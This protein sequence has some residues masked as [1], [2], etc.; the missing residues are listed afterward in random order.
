MELANITLTTDL[1]VIVDEIKEAAY[2]ASIKNGVYQNIVPEIGK[3]KKGNEVVIPVWEADSLESRTATEG[4]LIGEPIK[5]GNDTVR[6]TAKESYANTF[7]TYNDVEDATDDVKRRHANALGIA[8]ARD[9]EI[10]GQEAVKG[11]TKSLVTPDELTIADIMKMRAMLEMQEKYADGNYQCVSNS[12]LY[13]SLE[14]SL[15]DNPAFGTRGEVGDEFMKRYAI[16]TVLGNIDLLRSDT[17]VDPEA[18]TQD[19]AFFKKDALGLLVRRDYKFE[20]DHN[21]QR[22]GW[23]LIATQRKGIGI[24]DDALGMKFTAKNSLADPVAG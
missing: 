12:A 14:K 6:I 15:V 22:R 7:I 4:E 9:V 8:L 20:V 11:F 5:Y 1:P 18:L 21:P 2:E 3:G 23:E 17:N 16:G 13:H 19:G 10:A 24:V